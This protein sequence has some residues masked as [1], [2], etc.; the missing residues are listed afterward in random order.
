M[1]QLNEIKE[2]LYKAVVTRED[3]YAVQSKNGYQ[4]VDSNL[5]IEKYLDNEVTIGAYLLDNSNQV[6]CFCVD[7][8]VNKD[9]MEAANNSIEEFLLILQNQ[10]KDIVWVLQRADI[11][12]LIEFSGKKGYH[13]WGFFSDPVPAK[14][15]RI[16]LN[17]FEKE[18]RVIDNRLHW[19]LFPKQDKV[20]KDGYGSLIKL[21]LQVHKGT[22]KETF[23]VTK[24]FMEYLPVNIPFIE[25]A[26]LGDYEE[27]ETVED[28]RSER[29]ERSSP[30]QNMQRMIDNCEALRKLIEKA[31][32][33]HECSNDD[34][35]WMA[36]LFL[37]FGEKGR[38][39]VHKVLRHVN[40]YDKDKTNRHLDSLKGT[41]SLCEKMCPI[42]KCDRVKPTNYTSPIGFA[43]QRE[44][45]D[46]YEM[47]GRYM[48]RANGQGPDR[49]LTEWIIKPHELI[50]LGE[51]DV[52]R[53]DIIS[54]QGTCLKDFYIEND[55]WQ[56]KQ[57]LLRAL[58]HTELT[59]HGN[60]KD[61]QTLAHYLTQK[62]TSRKRGVKHL[63]IVGETFVADGINI[64]K[65]KISLDPA[66]K[67]FIRGED[68]IQKSVDIRPVGNEEEYRKLL[69]GIFEYMPNINKPEVIYP[70]ISWICLIPLKERIVR[71]KGAF[72]I[73]H[74]YG[75]QGTGKTSTAELLLRMYGYKDPT[76]LTCT[77][78]TFTLLTHLSSTNALPVILDEY[79]E[80]ELGSKAQ[81]IK[82]K[83]RGV[84][85]GELDSRGRQDQTITYYKLQAPVA[86]MGE[87]KI[88]DNALLERFIFVHFD[89]AIKE[90]GDS[91]Y[92]DRYQQLRGLP[93]EGFAA[94]YIKWAL[95]QNLGSYW[96]EAQEF[97][98]EIFEY[99]NVGPRVQYNWELLYCGLRL[100][101]EFAKSYGITTSEI[102]YAMIFK[103]QA[104]E[105]GLNESGY[106][107][108]DVDKL[109]EYIA[110][111]A[112]K[113]ILNRHFDWTLLDSDKVLIHAKSVLTE[114]RG[115]KRR[116]DETFYIMDDTSF[117]S[118][119]RQS[120][121]FIKYDRKLVNGVQRR[122]Y[123]L[124]YEKMIE[125]GLEVEG[126][127]N[128]PDRV[129]TGEQ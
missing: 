53:C 122:W 81:T 14:R 66:I 15:V 20:D 59:F 78:T 91:I 64:T 19:E 33:E 12:P 90:S 75:E 21:P 99:K 39:K 45:G 74:A 115:Y 31:E 116:Y 46:I 47:R 111:L 18:F 40:N 126:F 22:K 128:A 93:L 100:W 8:D 98:N 48:V 95:G 36:N 77:M 1:D 94:G 30:P 109:M 49:V 56:S 112:E 10:V 6:R 110:N 71:E 3:A 124:D 58:G 88:G 67:L 129:Y 79:R 121:Y 113:E 16:M 117:K 51:K 68:S 42:T 80:S 92:N 61:V 105:L 97:L 52:M 89:R 70:L 5:T 65:D 27:Q 82:E 96:V 44:P 29:T 72:F 17:S 4:K 119:I 57:K 63:G 103:N 101:E 120:K 43:Y 62:I 87:Y 84:Y 76:V 86:L 73:V 28:L 123:W 34:R 2:K 118:Q 26:K 54:M 9:A 104:E 125:D 69:S 102:P 106:A 7:I 50:D 13:V 23:F 35:V 38:Q 37:P 25:P 11:Q 60:E 108:R 127:M 85:R 24:E 107:K 83:L 55:A 41:P 114:L 32:R